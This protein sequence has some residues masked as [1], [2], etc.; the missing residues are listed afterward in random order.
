MRAILWMSVGAMMV[1]CGWGDHA[2]AADVSGCLGMHRHG[3]PTGHERCVGHRQRMV[4]AQRIAANR[5]RLRLPSDWPL[6][7]ASEGGATG[8][9]SLLYAF[10][11]LAGTFNGDLLPPGYVD[12]I[13]GP[14][15]NDYSC[16]GFAL[17]G[18]RGIDSGLRSFAEQLIGM[19]VF[20]ALDGVVIDANDGDPDMNLFPDG[21]DGNYI[22]LDNGFGRE[23]WY[24]HLKNGSVAFDVGDVV[25][26][27][28]QLGLA[29]SSGFSYG[30]H[31]HFESWQSGA[32]Y[33]P[34][35]GDCNVQPSGFVDQPPLL[36]DT[37]FADFG[38]TSQ[39]LFNTPG[40]PNPQPRSGQISFD[41]TFIYL[42]F[43]G[44]NFPVDVPWEFTFIRPD[45]TVALNDSGTLGNGEF[46]HYAPYFFYF[47][48]EDMHRIAGTW[49]V[50]V[51]F[52]GQL[53]V[54]APVEVVP[55][56][57]PGFNRPPEPITVSF[58]PAAP[59]AND[60]VLCRVGTSLTVDD[61]DYDVLSYRYVWTIDGRIVRDVTTA[62]H[63]D[64][65]R[66]SVASP[67]QTLVCEVTPSDGKA[68]GATAAAS[69]TFAGGCVGDINADGLVDGADLGMLL[70]MW[71]SAGGAADFDA[72]GT[73]DG[74]DLGLLLG[75]WGECPG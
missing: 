68:D 42:W 4:I 45:G 21:N 44:I 18:H 56:I 29:A 26:A 61:L 32:V 19:P 39:D 54:H 23:T 74:A 75:G 41:D 37:Y 73:V 47:Y 27:G 31:L 16:H 43:Q 34:F 13:S 58:E 70:G 9:E 67:G 2:R 6:K 15:A 66:R 36:L 71:D 25:L 64:M 52:N 3:E 10:W 22:I 14:G 55:V 38:I 11:P 62:A 12:V 72:S 30:P 33:D 20:A 60:V 24:F 46:L 50:D 5:E 40:L 59:E 48:V 51:K 53:M 63:S 69:W 49:H 35:A 57:D 17:D 65:L 1:L 8:S 7:Q 28:E